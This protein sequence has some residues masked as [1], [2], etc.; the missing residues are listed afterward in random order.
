[1]DPKPVPVFDKR[2][3]SACV[4]FDI[5]DYAYAVV[6]SLCAI[7]VPVPVHDIYVP[8]QNIVPVLVLKSLK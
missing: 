5:T 2:S 4:Y 6:L 3:K 8:V 7:L 1:M